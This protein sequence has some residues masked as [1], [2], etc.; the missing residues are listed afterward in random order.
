M[1]RL[2]P[3]RGKPV[4]LQLGSVVHEYMD[5][6]YTFLQKNKKRPDL[7]AFHNIAIDEVL[8]K[9]ARKS[10]ADIDYLHRH[11]EDFK[12]QEEIDD[13]LRLPDK[14]RAIAQMYFDTRGRHDAE[15]YD[16]LAVELRRN[17]QIAKRIHS[18]AAVDLVTRHKSTG[19]I[20]M[21]EHKTAKNIPNLAVRLVDIQTL[22]YKPMVE[23][24]LE[25]KVSTVNWNY[26]RT[27]LPD[28]PK[29]IYVGTKREAISTAQNVDTT[30][31]I[32]LEACKKFGKDPADYAEMKA[33][34]KDRELN[35][36]FPRLEQRIL[37]TDRMLEEYDIIA[38]RIHRARRS[39]EAGE[40]EPLHMIEY[41]CQWCEF[42]E[43][44]KAWALGADYEDII[45]DRFNV[46]P[47]GGE[48]NGTQDASAE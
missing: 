20:H 19:R 30:W 10:A 47:K 21:W 32:F 33:R 43:I 45:D 8:K 12:D 39:W 36:F 23:A 22:T 18:Q 48:M 14:A 2:V 26:L 4:Q 40:S 9:H 42:W 6:Y 28:E 15:E 5:I 11:P 13:I 17:T 37:T 16:V 44:C 46:R 7:V 1:L 24:A 35:A 38:R 29:L 31:P 34:L 3:K 25:V 27:K 41:T